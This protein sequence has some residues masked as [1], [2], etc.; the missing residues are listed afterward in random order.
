MSLK[1][2]KRELTSKIKIKFLDDIYP[3]DARAMQRFAD[4]WSYIKVLRIDPHRTPMQVFN[5][6]LEIEVLL[7]AP[8]STVKIRYSHF[9]CVCWH[10][11]H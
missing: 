1:E 10:C 8:K 2:A 3:R 9:V 4:M 11:T 5:E 7:Q 6:E